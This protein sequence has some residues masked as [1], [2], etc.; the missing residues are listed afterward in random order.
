MSNLTDILDDQD[1]N[2]PNIIST[3]NYIDTDTF[4]N[5]YKYTISNNILINLNIQSLPSKLDN[6]NI[7]L[8][9]IEDNPKLNLS[10]INL[11][12]TWLT[13]LQESSI[14]FYNFNIAYKHTIKGNIGGGLA[15]LIKKNINYTVRNDLSFPL[16]KQLLYD[17]LFVEI[18]LPNNTNIIIGNIYR[19]PG[20]S[21]IHEFNKELETL[22]DKIKKE[23][24]KIIIT[25]DFNINL[26]N[27]NVHK[28][29]TEFLD[30]WIAKGYL[31]QLTQPTRI[32]GN[33]ATLIDNIFT[34]SIN[35]CLI[36]RKGII[37]NDISDHYPAFIEIKLINPLTNSN[38]SKI[39]ESRHIT[40]QSITSLISDLN[41]ENWF[42][43]IEKMNTNDKYNSFISTYTK[44]MDKN[45]PKEK[46]KYN[47]YKHKNSQWI[48]KGIMKSIKYKD[49]LVNKRNKEKN[50]NRKAKLS[51][52]LKIYKSMLQK[53][54]RQAKANYWNYKF[55]E[56]QSNQKDT[57][58]H[59]RT[60]TKRTKNNSNIPDQLKDNNTL[61]TREEDIANTLNNHYVRVGQTLCNALPNININVESYLKKQPSIINSMFVSPTDE[62]EILN[63]TRGLTNKKSRGDDDIPQNLLKATIYSILTPLKNIIN[64]SLS[65]GI[66]PDKLKIAKVIPI[67]KKDDK[68]DP[69]NYRPVSILSCISKIFEKIIYNRTYNFLLK[70]S[71]FTNSQY[72]FLKH[73]STEDA[74]LEMQNTI[75]NNTT[76]NQTACS[77]FLDLSKAFDTINHTIL[78]NKLS[79]YGIRGI[80]LKLLQNYLSNRVQYT[81]IN[82]IKSK[83]L[84]INMGV[85]QG[86]ILGPL[87]FLIYVNDL[88]L[89]VIVPIILFA[90]DTS[91]IC[92]ANN[93]NNLNKEISDAL[94]KTKAWLTTNKLTLNLNT[95]KII[96][97]SKN[98]S[99]KDNHILNINIENT[100]I[101]IVTYYKFLGIIIDNKLTWKNH[102]NYICNKI[103]RILYIMKSIKHL[104]SSDIL[105]TIYTS[106]IQP[107]LMYGIISWYNPDNNNTKR[108][109]TLQKKAI[110]IISKTKYYAHTS[111]LFQHL[112]I[113]KLKDIY[114]KQTL[115]LYWKFINKCLPPNIQNELILGNEIHSHYTRQ[116]NKLHFTQVRHNLDRQSL[117][118]KIHKLEINTPYELIT[119]TK[120]LPLKLAKIKIKKFLLKKYK[121]ECNKPNCFSCSSNN[122]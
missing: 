75:I 117:N 31:P 69:N 35:N 101:E 25:G 88:P 50:I 39:I 36:T 26:L 80:T 48:T 106:L 83:Y 18:K 12:E 95:T 111:N 44:L 100:N 97:F 73:R 107:H 86:S 56:A 67:Y 41:K 27:T 30:T 76:N 45:M 4:I 10:F 46:R 79:Y 3:S 71:V 113:L 20:Q 114:I 17:S 42:D 91:L 104:V 23:T 64:S 62:T 40:N 96:Q 63:I 89:T 21:P 28:P 115:I 1:Y 11:Q 59:I 43:V 57:W 112:N 121:F 98:I 54:K 51:A 99:P 58:N 5:N 70:Q 84:P 8:D 22:L 77:L 14:Q 87:L 85:P 9:R 16:N 103:L 90:D 15:I 92:K 66:F 55:K 6:L 108:L 74:L 32:T 116:T 33:T 78:K 65:S 60:L 24:T 13:E 110:R 37:T 61:I 53:I 34:K 120:E 122:V 52:K 119:I 81:E 105:R 82:S 19:S 47:K 109:N 38:K 29:T 94:K 68:S 93:T 102:I 72:G 2:S 7:L 49:K 118:Y